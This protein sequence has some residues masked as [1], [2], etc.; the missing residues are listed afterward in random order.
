MIDEVHVLVVL[1]VDKQHTYRGRKG[2]PTINYMC[3]CDFDM[4]FTFAYVGWEGSTYDIR[5]FLGCLNNDY[6]NFPKSPLGLYCC[7]LIIVLKYVLCSENAN[8]IN[9]LICRKIFSC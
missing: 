7:I 1:L 6:D 8:V 3:A 2:E 4:K 9:I 5:I